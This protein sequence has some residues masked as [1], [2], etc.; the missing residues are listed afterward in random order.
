RRVYEGQPI[1]LT[2]GYFNAIWQ[3]DANSYALRCLELCEAPPRV[4]NVTGPETI[5][6][7][8]AADF[9]ARRFQ[10]AAIFQGEESS[11]ALLNNSSLCHGLL[12]YPELPLAALMEWV[13]HWVEIGGASL[14]KPTKYEVTDG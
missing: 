7:R 6:V 2:M 9:F 11:T 13:A 8:R 1:D 3:G 5:S 10:R 4:L 12:G 14:G